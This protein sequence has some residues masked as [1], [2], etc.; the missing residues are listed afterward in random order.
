[1]DSGDGDNA[2]TFPRMI[3]SW[4]ITR[5]ARQTRADYRAAPKKWYFWLAAVLGIMAFLLQMNFMS[6]YGER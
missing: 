5:L 6:W 1:M 3:E 2:T 4:S